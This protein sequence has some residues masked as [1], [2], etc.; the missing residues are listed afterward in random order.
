MPRLNLHLSQEEQDWLD[1]HTP[2]GA[3]AQALVRAI[4][5]RVGALDAR[6]SGSD[7]HLS[8]SQRMARQGLTL[9]DVSPISVQRMGS[10]RKGYDADDY[11]EAVQETGSISGAAR[12]LGVSRATVREQCQRHEIPVESVGGVPG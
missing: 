7:L 2:D 6:E 9:R 3:T 8:E 10:G 11:R 5:A 1:E 12:M 4:I